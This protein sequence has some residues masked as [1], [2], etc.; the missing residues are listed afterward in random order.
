MYELSDNR[1]RNTN[2]AS[3][4]QTFEVERWLRNIQ[5]SAAMYDDDVVVDDDDDDDD[6]E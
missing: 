2:I 5:W 6:D 3:I 1:L 4:R